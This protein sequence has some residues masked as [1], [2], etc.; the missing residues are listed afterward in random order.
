MFKAPAIE[1]LRAANG[2]ES[3]VMDQLAPS[4]FSPY[5]FF[6]A[7]R[8][9]EF[10]ADTPMTLTYDEVKR[11]RSL[12]DPIDLDEVSRIYLS[13]SRL[14]SAHVE[15][16][17]FCFTSAAGFSTPTMRSRRPSSSALPV[18]SPSESRQRPAF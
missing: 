18:Q 13:L 1:R 9:A 6:S 16:S 10:R 8:W 17:Q 15:A 7:E 12:G 5:R 2:T 3:D 14:L 11:L 4:E